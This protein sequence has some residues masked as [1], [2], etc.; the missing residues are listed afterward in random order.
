MFPDN[1]LVN[2]RI[3]YL[4]FAQVLT[5]TR[6]ADGWPASFGLSMVLYN[7]RNGFLVS[8][9]SKPIV[10]SARTVAPVFSRV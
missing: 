8:L 5:S 6:F 2:V 7:T 4:R 10:A 3:D 9:P 1:A